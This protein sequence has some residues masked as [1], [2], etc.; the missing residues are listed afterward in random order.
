MHK[1]LIVD[2][3]VNILKLMAFALRRKNY[4]VETRSEIRIPVDSQD[5][6]GFDII[7]LDVMMTNIEGTDICKSIRSSVAT[8]IIF[9]S[10]KAEEEDIL[11]GFEVGGDD[12]IT[13]PFSLKQL[14]A[15]VEA[16]IIREERRKGAHRSFTAIR[17]DFGRL[18]FYLEEKRICIDGDTV[19][20][21]SREYD[22]LELLSSYPTKV[23]SI[24]DIY[25]HVYDEDA[26]ALLRSISEYIY[27]IRKKLSSY[28]VEVVKTVRGKGYQWHV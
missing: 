23:F 10:A 17:R 1:I 26:D 18:T 19:P 6:Q 15:K 14:V 22:I 20:F 24:D 16:N 4:N 21:T 28:G 8:P 13:K 12:Y 7:L 9:V 25:T 3:D 27:Q 5:F 11:T 2:D